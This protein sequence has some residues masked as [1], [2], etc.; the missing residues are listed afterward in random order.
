[1]KLRNLPKALLDFQKFVLL[2][3]KEEERE[4]KLQKLNLPFSVTSWL[5]IPLMDARIQHEYRIYNAENKQMV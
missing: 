1:M 2:S 5:N 3:T 4:Q